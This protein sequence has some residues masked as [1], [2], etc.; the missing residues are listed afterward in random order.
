MCQHLFKFLLLD[1]CVL[2][3]L[4]VYAPCKP[5][6]AGKFL[7]SMTMFPFWF[8]HSNMGHYHNNKNH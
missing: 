7:Q 8:L 1:T 5:V 4:M 6:L 2:K 3:E